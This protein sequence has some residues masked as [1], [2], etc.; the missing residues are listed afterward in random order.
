[1]KYLL[2]I[3][4]L[5]I[6]IG[7]VQSQ[8]VTTEPV[9]V[10]EDESVTITFYADRG[11]R[12][13]VN[14]TGEIYAHTGVITNES[15]GSSDWRYVIAEWGEN[16]PKAKLTMVA[17]N[18]HQLVID[19]IREYYGVPAE[20][21]ILQ[22]A[23]VFRSATQINGSWREGK[24]TDGS[25]IFIDV[26]KPELAVVFQ[27]PQDDML[28]LANEEITV[29]GHSMNA[30]GM[31]LY[32]NE[33]VIHET[34]S[35]TLEHTFAAPA[36]GVHELKL[37]AF[38][39]DNSVF[40]TRS[41][42]I[43]Q[44]TVEE[45]KPEGL[46]L[47]ANVIDEETVTFVLQAPFK[48]YVY[49]IGDFNDWEPNP[50]SQMK[51]DGEFYWLTINDLE[52]GVEYAYQY[53][54]DGSLRLADAYTNKVL[55]PWN[56]HYIPDRIYPNLKPFPADK[57]T[58]LAAV[59][60][61]APEVYP[62]QVVDFSPPANEDLV[63]YE[64][65]IRDFTSNQDIKTIT[66]TLDYFVRLGVNAIQLMPFNQF[67]GNESWGYNPSFFFATDK[68]YGT[69][70]D[71]KAFI[72]ACH[73]RGIAVIMDIVLNHTFSQ[74][75][76]LQM[77]FQGGRAAS[78][79]PWY[80]RDNNIQNPHLQWG[81]P[82]NHES[83]Y[84]Q[85][86]VDS[87]LS[88]WVTEFN[89]DGYRF[90][91]TKGFTN[92]PYGPNSWASE[93]DASRVAILKRMVDNL[94]EVKDDAIIIFEH[95]ADN[96]EETVLADYGILLW[97]N[98]NYS[99]S[100]AVMGYHDG[101][102]SD[103]SWASYSNRGWSNPNLIAYMESH[104]EERV[105]FRAL[106]YGA[107][108]PGYSVKNLR[109]ALNRKKA[110]AAF[111]F[112]IPG[113]KMIWQFGELGFDY[114]IDD[115]GGRL[116]PKPPKWDYL[117]NA[118]RKRLW[119]VYSQMI[120]L[121]REEA[122]FSTTD[123]NMNVAGAVK[124]IALN[125]ESNDIRLVGNFDTQTRTVAPQFSSTGWWYNHFKGDSIYVEDL[126]L[127]VE[128]APGAFTLFSSTKMFGFDPT[129]SIRDLQKSAVN[130]EMYPI[131][132]NDKLYVQSPYVISSVY[133][134]DANGR[135]LLQRIVD[136]HDLELETSHLSAGFYFIQ[137]VHQNGIVSR[138]KFLK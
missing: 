102:K 125:H 20:E 39:Q 60:N 58:G 6:F 43:R 126:S 77:Y 105:M 65:L 81:F 101:G 18:R 122:V 133:V 74:S 14:F 109:N 22:M 100:E 137:V 21:E 19:N 52:P 117:E 73:E 89:I 128:L 29:V 61:T 111:L 72:D 88:F 136:D 46:R 80:L 94:R 129:T 41:L 92:T 120:H 40:Q 135:Q 108:V 53:F 36:S 37:E 118:D 79:N 23:F 13:L 91:F 99:F 82:L 49:L 38:D 54:I 66:D 1:M 62:W 84:T 47:G 11:S 96:S 106:N 76:L 86:L 45:P 114:S 85:A 95:L 4:L 34:S 116:A 138:R 124:H 2:Q 132:V 24:D 8:V 55:D 115:F 15:T 57:T 28:V 42:F 12:G 112:S 110:A 59:V 27:S 103:F 119:N 44:E 56:D 30:D 83:E 9:I 87:V 97:G 7:G 104:D 35:S 130:I 78:N 134:F 25:D 50:D 131:P 63:I 127:E 16:I 70:N 113:P 3:I 32:L 5:F 71:Y 107:E 64:V 10:T 68:A 48:E 98:M 51:R 75:P 31:K 90:D 33:D 93:Y 69:A 121:K 123:Y 17:Y 26:F 67:E